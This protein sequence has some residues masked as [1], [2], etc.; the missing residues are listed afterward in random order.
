MQGREWVNLKHALKI[1]RYFFL[2]TSFS[3]DF[4]KY[5]QLCETIIILNRNF[6]IIICFTYEI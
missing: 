6:K 2:T 1:V 3:S 5:T 4:T